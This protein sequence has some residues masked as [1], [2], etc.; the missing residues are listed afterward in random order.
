MYLTVKLVGGGGAGR[1][2]GGTQG[3][4]LGDGEVGLAGGRRSS[5]A[6]GAAEGL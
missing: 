4:G 1:G 3:G 5:E 2:G 6:G